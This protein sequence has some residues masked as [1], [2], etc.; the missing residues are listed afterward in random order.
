MCRSFDVLFTNTNHL[1]AR[2]FFTSNV[3]GK[4]YYTVH[5]VSFTTELCETCLE[6]CC[7]SSKM[8]KYLAR[9][10]KQKNKYLPKC[11][12]RNESQLRNKFWLVS[13]D[14]ATQNTWIYDR[15]CD[16]NFEKYYRSCC[17]SRV[18]CRKSKWDKY[19]WP[20]LSWK[21]DMSI[22]CFQIGSLCCPKF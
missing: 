8:F 7:S 10:T 5:I 12:N 21:V 4:V 16:W 1:R 11:F 2:N 3:F 19:F 22:L 14:H 13:W 6:R 9:L 15:S 20:G 18:C 17:Q